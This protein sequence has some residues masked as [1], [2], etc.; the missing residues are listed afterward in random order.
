MHCAFSPHTFPGD[1]DDFFSL[2]I[3]LLE[4]TQLALSV[5]VFGV[6]AEYWVVYLKG[7]TFER[8]YFGCCFDDSDKINVLVH[9]IAYVL[10]ISKS[11]LYVLYIFYS[12]FH[13]LTIACLCRILA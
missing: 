7:E 1:L 11:G 12:S 3:V 5:C 6:E 10:Y 8:Q 2:G 4:V 13:A 9:R